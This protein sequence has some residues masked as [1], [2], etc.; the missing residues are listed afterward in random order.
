MTVPKPP[1]EL[2]LDDVRR[3][4]DDE[5]AHIDEKLTAFD[6]FADGVRVETDAGWFLVRAS[7]TEPLVRI[8][9]EARG[10]ADADALFETTQ[11]LVER[12]R[13]AA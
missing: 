9:A 8:T 12:V 3:L 11:D 2:S 13:D 7:G 4:V 10:E 1:A 6:R 5:Q